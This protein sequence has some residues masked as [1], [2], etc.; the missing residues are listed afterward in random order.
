MAF[1]LQ[2]WL[3]LRRRVLFLGSLRL[4]CIILP[5]VLLLC[6]CES[7]L[8]VDAPRKSIPLDPPDNTGRLVVP[9]SLSMQLYLNFA[10][11]SSRIELHP[12]TRTT[13]VWIDTSVVP[14]LLWADVQCTLHDTISTVAPLV[15]DEYYLLDSL[16]FRVDSVQSDRPYQF[17]NAPDAGTGTV[18]RLQKMS[19]SGTSLSSLLI[20]PPSQ[21]VSVQ[22]YAFLS[23]S[24]FT[25][26]GRKEITG[27]YSFSALLYDMVSEQYVNVPIEGILTAYYH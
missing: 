1:F 21:P 11:N 12:R 22:S 6:G 25:S 17:R 23:L 7:S 20:V 5:A 4:V 3:Y 15:N 19:A 2:T 14:H 18:I 16:R 9:D 8:D 26:Q 27:S 10:W 13:E 24:A